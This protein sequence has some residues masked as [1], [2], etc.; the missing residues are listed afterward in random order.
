MS[1][2]FVPDCVSPSSAQSS[3]PS[4]YCQPDAFL[5]SLPPPSLL[6]MRERF[7]LLG[8]LNSMLMR[9]L[10]KLY[11]PTINVQVG[12]VK[13]L[14][15][16]TYG[17]RVKE[18]LA[19]AA[20]ECTRSKELLGGFFAPGLDLCSPLQEALMRLADSPQESCRHLIRM[21]EDARREI[22]SL[23]TEID[24][25][26]LSESEELKMLSGAE[27]RALADWLAEETDGYRRDASGFEGQTIQEI[28]VADRF[29]LTLLLAMPS[30]ESKGATP[31]RV[32]VPGQVA[33]A[34]NQGVNGTGKR[35]TGGALLNKPSVDWLETVYKQ[36]IF[37]SI[38]DRSTLI[39]KQHLRNRPPCDWRT[40]SRLYASKLL[41]SNCR[42]DLTLIRWLQ[43][44]P[45]GQ[46]SDMPQ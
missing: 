34:E 42:F 25:S 4:E 12:D 18:A 21:L 28:D 19:H 43:A 37:Q 14:P 16:F 44:Q 10:C 24:S 32:M 23:E 15:L 29:L 46:L 5:T 26:V 13:R 31:A 1:N 27:R 30:L 35:T 8:Y 9:A 11:N 38:T 39:L 22:T 45:T 2:I 17:R 3:S 41:E 33:D 36:P 6:T 40:E 20:I 7:G